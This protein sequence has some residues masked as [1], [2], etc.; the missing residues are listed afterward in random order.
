MT[1]KNCIPTHI[2]ATVFQD[3]AI[4]LDINKNTYYRLNESAAIFWKYLTEECDFEIA[5]KKMSELYDVEEMMLRDDMQD[6]LLSFLRSKI[7]VNVF[8]L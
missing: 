2:K 8:N 7:I 3:G 5:L 6:L 4:L 1:Q